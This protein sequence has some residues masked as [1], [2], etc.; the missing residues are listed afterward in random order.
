MGREKKAV[1]IYDISRMTGVSVATVSRVLNG[2]ARV[3]EEKR[4]LV[5][6]AVRASGFRP[7]ELARGLVRNQSRTIGCVVPDTK[8]VFYSSLY[9]EL[10]TL[11]SEQGYAVLLTNS[12]GDY[13][14]ETALLDLLISK[15]VDAI[16]FM[17]GRIDVNN[18]APAYH[19][20]LEEIHRKVPIVLTS[21]LEGIRV[22][23]VY[24]QQNE[25]VR[26]LMQHLRD[27]GCRS[28]GVLGGGE[29]SNVARRRRDKILKYGQQAG[30]HTRP[31]WIVMNHAFSV[32]EGR[33]DAA[34]IFERPEIPDVICCM[35]DLVA[36]GAVD[37]IQ[38]I[39]LRV[40]DDMMVAGFD[41][42][43]LSTAVYPGITTVQMDAD[44]YARKIF[45]VLRALIAHEPCALQHTVPARV[46]VRGS[47]RRHREPRRTAAG[48][49]PAA[50]GSG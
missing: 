12:R 32:D 17:G 7:N 6:E 30:M 20:A 29:E 13:E 4:R 16:V 10:E 50:R 48:E 35:N 14:R 8:N 49:A 26:C 36:L 5:E 38:Q 27:Q 15:Q 19:H 18:C 42:T 34:R 22:P 3:S 46:V 23:Q 43:Y 44:L 41:G 47:T 33:A 31:D 28:F 2:T 9:Y 21:K 25:A 1:T 40:P 24:G 39:G 45:E 11:A 37:Y